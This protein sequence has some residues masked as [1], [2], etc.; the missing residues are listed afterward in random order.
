MQKPNL[1]FLRR[2]PN[3]FQLRRAARKYPSDNRTACVWT[4]SSGN[5]RPAWESFPA[6]Q[7]QLF[8]RPSSET[9]NP[10]SRSL[11]DPVERR[12]PDRSNRNWMLSLRHIFSPRPGSRTSSFT[13]ARK[14]SP[15]ESV[16]NANSDEKFF[17]SGISPDV[18][19]RDRGSF[20]TGVPAGIS[21]TLSK[22]FCKAPTRRTRYFCQSEM[23]NFQSSTGVIDSSSSQMPGVT[24]S[25]MIINRAFPRLSTSSVPSRNRSS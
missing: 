22:S 9:L 10:T 17:S 1:P 25:E 14:I 2:F 12:S 7:H 5:S 19:S 3:S 4:S 8:T 24:S 6:S 16:R 11:S 15:T 18:F 23:G 21:I 20:T 13:L